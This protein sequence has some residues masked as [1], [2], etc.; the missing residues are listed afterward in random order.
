MR[1]WLMRL[2]LSGQRRLLARQRLHM[3]LEGEARQRVVRLRFQVAARDAP[4]AQRLEGGK[5]PALEQRADEC[6]DEHRLAGAR[7]AG[8]AEAHRRADEPLRKVG[9]AARGDARAIHDV[10]ERDDLSTPLFEAP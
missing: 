7:Q 5:A 6:R 2:V 1:S 8:D 10:G 4:A 3:R 9:E